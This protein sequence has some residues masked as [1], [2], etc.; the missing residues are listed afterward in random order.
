[1]GIQCFRPIASFNS[2]DDY[3]LLEQE[4][5]IFFSEDLSFLGEEIDR[6]DSG[7]L[8][9]TVTRY[10]EIVKS[11]RLCLLWDRA[12]ARLD[13]EKL[14]GPCSEDGPYKLQTCMALVKNSN[15]FFAQSSDSPDLSAF[16][17][18]VQ[19]GSDLL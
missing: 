7:L 2:L 8:K 11:P 19:L 9:Q 15:D 4:E 14:A 5:G 12:F 13:P 1:M 10:V 3:R 17:T 18:C 6:R 16:F